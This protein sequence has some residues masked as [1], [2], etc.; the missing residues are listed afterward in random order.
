LNRKYTN[1]ERL[2]KLAEVILIMGQI[3]AVSETWQKNEAPG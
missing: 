1:E 3:G 2:E